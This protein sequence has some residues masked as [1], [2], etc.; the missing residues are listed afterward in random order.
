MMAKY[1]EQ[2]QVP[3]SEVDISDPN[4]V[5]EYFGLPNTKP[6][7]NSAEII[8]CPKKE[9]FALLKQAENGRRM[10]QYIR[11]LRFDYFLAGFGLSAF[12][13]RLATSSTSFSWWRLIVFLFL[14]AIG[15]G[16]FAFIS[17]I[18]RTFLFDERNFSQGQRVLWIA[19]IATVIIFGVLAFLPASPDM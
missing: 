18:V 13:T 1:W 7:T 12:G 19:V 14:G 3:E 17:T 5:A 16:L 6:S 8:S 11:S 4:A 2:G 9:Y 15:T 10:P